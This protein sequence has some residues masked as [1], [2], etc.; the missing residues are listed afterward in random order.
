MAS[1]LELLTL[2]RFAGWPAARAYAT[3][4]QSAITGSVQIT[5]GATSFD[6]L[7]G[8]SGTGVY[9]VAVAG[10][11]RCYGKIKLAATASSWVHC[12]LVRNGTVVTVGP[13][14][15]TTTATDYGCD[16]GD[17]I[18]CT[19]GDTLALYAASASSIATALPDTAGSDVYFEVHLV[20]WA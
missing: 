5:L 17:L 4:T 16:V 1:T 11:Y 7:G 2:A 6:N 9:T 20:T 8:F 10:V 12:Q 18:S 3:T 13:E 14:V 19:V 15:P